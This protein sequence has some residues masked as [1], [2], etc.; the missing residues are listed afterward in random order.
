[1]GILATYFRGINFRGQNVLPEE[2]LRISG[3]KLCEGRFFHRFR[4]KTFASDKKLQP[5]VKKIS[6]LKKS[7][8]KNFNQQV[9]LSSIDNTLYFV[10]T[11]TVTIYKVLWPK[12]LKIRMINE[13][14]FSLR[15]YGNQ[16]LR[17]MKT[18]LLG[19]LTIISDE[20]SESK[21]L[22]SRAHR[23]SSLVA[24]RHHFHMTTEDR[25]WDRR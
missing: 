25:R 16:A 24:G 11:V 12:S 18:K 7:E 10:R 14:R 4:I 15:L 3:H 19:A 6:Q 5:N 23:R 1:M 17:F 22:F 20:L 13:Q 21:I 2:K 8:G 9:F